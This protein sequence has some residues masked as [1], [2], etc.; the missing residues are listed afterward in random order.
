MRPAIRRQPDLAGEVRTE[1]RL[2]RTLEA[3]LG[4]HEQAREEAYLAIDPDQLARSLPG[5]GENGGPALLAGMGRPGRFPDAKSFRRYTGFTPKASETGESDAKGTAMTKADSNR[6]R[7][8][9]VLSANTARRIDPELARFYWT[10]MVE[11]GP[12]LE[13]IDP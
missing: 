6:L 12:P 4:I 9:L 11:R 5:I 1:V 3:E 8:Q 13:R 10:Q 2:V 7:T